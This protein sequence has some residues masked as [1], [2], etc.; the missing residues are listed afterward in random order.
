MC[1]IL[2][3]YFFFTTTQQRLQYKV[4]RSNEALKSWVSVKNRTKTKTKQKKKPNIALYHKVLISVPDCFQAANIDF[5]HVQLKCIDPLTVGKH[6]VVDRAGRRETAAR[7]PGVVL[8]HSEPLPA[9][10]DPGAPPHC[11]RWA[12]HPSAHTQLDHNRG[13]KRLFPVA[14]FE[15]MKIYCPFALKCN[16]P[17]MNLALYMILAV[18]DL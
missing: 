13:L 1:C 18:K 4:E 11:R 8:L 3:L 17:F 2:S 14:R 16:N 10:V 12:L 15:R 9:A 5:Y 7:R 6:I